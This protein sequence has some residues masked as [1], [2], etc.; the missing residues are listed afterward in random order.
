MIYT[1]NIELLLVSVLVGLL[2]LPL[3]QSLF[4]ALLF[5]SYKILNRF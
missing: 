1:I 5:V 3:L 4:I 2:V